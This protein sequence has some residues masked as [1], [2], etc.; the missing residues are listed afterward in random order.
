[1]RFRRRLGALT[2]SIHGMGREQGHSGPE[3]P[4]SSTTALR[5]VSM[6]GQ[7]DLVQYHVLQY[8]RLGGKVQAAA[9]E[10]SPTNWSSSAS[11]T[12]GER[13]AP[14]YGITLRCV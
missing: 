10:H 12:R 7:A 1:M 4:R 11:R 6:C 5:Q 9:P 13:F 3:C 8:A 14:P 2:L